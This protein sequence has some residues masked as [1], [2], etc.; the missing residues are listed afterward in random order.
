MSLYTYRVVDI[1]DYHK[2]VMKSSATMV[3]N[4][5]ENEFGGPSFSFIAPNGTFWTLV[6]LK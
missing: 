1:D 5:T 2:K 6:G 4:V 3:K